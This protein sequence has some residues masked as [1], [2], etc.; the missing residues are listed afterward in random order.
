LQDYVVT[1]EEVSYK[2]KEK[3]YKKKVYSV[4]IDGTTGKLWRIAEKKTGKKTC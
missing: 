2:L 4:D 1:S 3:Y